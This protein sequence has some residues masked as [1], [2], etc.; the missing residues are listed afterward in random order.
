MYI[1]IRETPR[2]GTGAQRHKMRGVKS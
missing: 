1:Y 2:C